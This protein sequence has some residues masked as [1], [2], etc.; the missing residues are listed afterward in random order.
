[1]RTMKRLSHE[2]IQGYLDVDYDSK[3]ALVVETE[4]N[5]TESEIVG[6]VQYFKDPA[7][8]F[9]EVA[10]VVR[11]D[12]QNHGIGTFLF[13]HLIKVARRNGISG[14]TAEV[15][16]ENRAMQSVFNKS[17]C[18]LQSEVNGDV[19]SYRMKFD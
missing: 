16:R 3:M 13:S 18:K 15:L 4:N 6:I 11:D 14:L 2:E 12:W 7:T 9:A 5:G 10:F 8:G 19:Y 17:N 1:M